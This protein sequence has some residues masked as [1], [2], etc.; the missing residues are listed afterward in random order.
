[1]NNELENIIKQYIVCREDC[2]LLFIESLAMNG[3]VKNAHIENCE[4][5]NFSRI[6]LELY[7]NSIVKSECRYIDEISHSLKIINTYIS[8]SRKHRAYENLKIL[9]PVFTEDN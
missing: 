4:K 3:L 5:K 1:M 6:V 8:F 2:T 7:D 9:K